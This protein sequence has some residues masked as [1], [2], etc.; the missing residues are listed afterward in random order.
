MKNRD[1]LSE[2]ADHRRFT[3]PFWAHPVE[4]AFTE[5]GSRPTGLTNGEAAQRIAKDGPNLVSGKQH[6]GLLAKAFRRISEPLTA[7]LLVSAAV[8][9][10]A[11]DWQS[12]IIIALIVSFSIV[13]DIYQ[14]REAESAIEALKQSVAVRAT[15]LRDGHPIELAVK[16]IVRGD[17]VELKAGD[18]VPAD[19]FII[20]GRNTLVNEA[21]LTG[22]PFPCEKRAGACASPLIAEAHNALFAGTSLVAGD[23]VM[24]VAET[25]AAT[26]FGTIATSLQAREPM[27]AFERGAHGLGMLIMRLTA[28]LVLFVLLTQLARHGLS[29]ESFMFAVALAVGL[30]PELLPMIMTVTLARGAIRMAKRK[31]V[32]KRLSAIHDL[33]AMNVLCTDKT[34]TLTEA[35][36]ALV[37]SLGVDG[38]ANDSAAKLMRLNSA[39]VRGLRSNLDEA[40][41]AAGDQADADWRLVDDAPFDFDRRRSSVLVARGDRTELITKGAP[42]TVLALCTSVELG[43]GTIASLDEARKSALQALIEQ[44]GEQGLRLLGVARRVLAPDAAKITPDDET[45]MTFVGCASFLDPPKASATEAVE[46]LTSAGVG[47]KIISGDAASVVLNLVKILKVPAKGLLTGDELNA[48]SDTALAEKAATVDLFVRVS[49]DQKGRI[50]RALRLRGYT[51]GFLG[52]GIN[53]ATAIHAADVGLSVEGGTDVARDAAD[54]ILLQPDLSVLADG[55]AEGR[56]TYANIMKYV[57]MGTSSNFGNMLSMALA[58][59]MLPFLPLTPLQILLNNLLYDLSEVGIPFDEADKSVLARPQTWDISSIL[60]FTLVMG[61][62]SS[63]FDLGTFFVLT[64]V[65]HASA[66]V[67]QTAW[68]VESITTQVLVIFIIRTAHPIWTSRP[69]AVLTATSLSALA[70]ALIVALSPLG[71]FAGFVALPPSILAAI[72]II[73]VTYLALAEA[74]KPVALYWAPKIPLALPFWGTRRFFQR[75]G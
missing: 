39:L 61:P 32:V 50:V 7:I 70:V 24:L 15:V 53:D 12:F 31:V 22:E 68:F 29:L 9:G 67:F 33:G 8:S 45:E 48:L 57:R 3:A 20:S 69:N 52:D 37:E 59:L 1:R 55:V 75:F 64:S 40:I 34:G 56:R 11:G 74:A 44:K 18:L 28:F 30:T 51:V 19:G 72:A 25:G 27:A 13:L 16:D 21:S 5:L 58:S 65:F 62:L 60:G 54:I 41:L 2:T 14:E 23:A 36:V 26:T 4:E 73:T 46:K 49:P 35:K 71:H 47:V 17:V 38:R 6:R 43:D 42:E 66:E 10:S 63:V